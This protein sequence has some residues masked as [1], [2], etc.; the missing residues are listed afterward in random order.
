VERRVAEGDAW[1]NDSGIPRRSRPAQRGYGGGLYRQVSAGHTPPPPV[2]PVCLLPVYA[3]TWLV[4]TLS[5][6]SQ[7]NLFMLY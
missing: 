1:P 2:L 4:V 5:A 7:T 3:S 6:S